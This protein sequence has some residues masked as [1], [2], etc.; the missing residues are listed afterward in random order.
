M[1]PTVIFSSEDWYG[2]CSARRPLCASVKIVTRKLFILMKS[3]FKIDLLV[4]VCAIFVLS[5]KDN[6]KYSSVDNNSK[7][8]FNLSDSLKRGF[9]GEIYSK[10]Q[11]HRFLSD[12]TSNLLN[13]EIL[14]N[15]K[16]S[17][18]E[19]AE[20][21]L[22]KVY[23]KE[24]IINQRP[25]EIYLFG[26]YWIMNGTLPRNMKGGTFSIALNRKTCKVIGIAHGK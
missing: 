23:G 10:E 20:P 26:D 13:G 16:E 12:S 18:I 24:K 22:Y 3:I 9:D 1:L 2:T 4:I 25:Y 21:I 6:K 19:I 11:L 17:L 8:I 7:I 14:I 15:D 5:C